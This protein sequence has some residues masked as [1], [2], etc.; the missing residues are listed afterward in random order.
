MLAVER[1]NQ[2]YDR[3]L[4]YKKVVVGELSQ[5][6]KVSE[7]TIRR[8]LDR[9]E[10]DGLA[11][12][13]YGGAILNENTNIDLPFN[14]RK[15]HNVSGKQKIAELVAGLVESGDHIMLDPSS[16]AVFIAKALK[17]K[18]RLTVVTNSIEVML[19][20]SDMKEW[21]IIAPGGSIRDGILALVGP[22]ATEGIGAYNVEKSIISCKGFDL[23]KG[24]SDTSE[25]FAHAKQRMLVSA[26]VRILA[27]D[28]SKFGQSAFSKVG[29]LSNIDMIVTDV[30]PDERTLEVL[31][32]AKVQ[33]IYP[34]D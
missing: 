23:E 27:V 26:K 22:K 28:S 24:F 10:R 20:L 4:T 33:C 1:R 17:Q 19:E 31:E 6:Y 34:E 7:E 30:K 11:I 16:T 8:D 13:S 14:V 2:I 9:L 12:K 3:L 21:N 18:E 29:D 5:E 32:N 25:D 15:K